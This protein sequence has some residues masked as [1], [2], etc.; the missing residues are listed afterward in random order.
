MTVTQFFAILGA[1]WKLCLQICLGT[2]V[3]AL[4]ISF[5]LPKRYTATAS[6][7]LDAKPDPVSAMLYNSSLSPGFV[8]TQVDIIQSERVAL[9]VVRNLK[10]G[11]NPAIR[12]QWSQQSGD[13][14]TL[15]QW[16]VDSFQRN[17]DVKPAR[18]S[19]V[20][21]V[22]YSAP[23]PR[24]AAALANAFVQAY[25]ETNLELRTDPAKQYSSYF[26]ARA[27]TARDELEAA[28]NKVSAFQKAKSI[29]A[30]DER[31]DVENQRLNDLSGQLVSVQAQATDSSSRQSAAAG[32]AGERMQEVLSNPVVSGLQ[33]DLARAEARLQELSARYGDAHP[34]VIESKANIAE[35]KKRVDAETKKITGG[36]GVSNSINQQRVADLRASLEVQRN[37][38]LQ[39]KAVRDE[40]QVLLKDADNAQRNYDAVVARLNQSNLESQVTQSNVSPLAFATPPVKPSSPKLV[41]NAAVATFLGLL[42]AVGVALALEL[43]DRRVR[44]ADDVVQAIGVPV[45]GVMPSPS[46]RRLFSATHANQLMQ[47]RLLGQSGS[48]TKGA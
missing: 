29:I 10:M 21:N 16:L 19:N 7:V 13:G 44:S 9:K 6:V 2:V 38:V 18:E 32:G 31:F 15:E 5:L 30:T 25:I 34:Q 39:M 26:D 8:A 40:G 24:F 48:A 46:A 17:L 36:V 35:L 43:F 11:D 33:A 47:K 27:K 4:A 37:K 42:L 3:L 14:G 45:L 12:E 20:I 41:L 28:Q 1:R 22:T 23:D